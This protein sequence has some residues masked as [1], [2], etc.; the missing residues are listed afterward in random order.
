MI[1]VKRSCNSSNRV[2]DDK[3]VFNSFIIEMTGHHAKRFA[4]LQKWMMDDDK[5]DRVLMARML[6]NII[7]EGLFTLNQSMEQMIVEKRRADANDH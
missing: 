6:E 1:I 3:I 7:D 5:F 2:D 4:A